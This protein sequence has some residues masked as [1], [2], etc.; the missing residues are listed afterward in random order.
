MQGMSSEKVQGNA[1]QVLLFVM[2][3]V[4]AFTVS[5]QPTDTDIALFEAAKGRLSIDMLE[6]GNL[7][8]VQAL[9]LAS[10]YMQKRNKPNSGYNYMGL[11]RRIAMGIA[12]H[13]EFPTW[14]TN[15]LTIEMRRRVW[16]C[17]YIFD[18]GAIITFSRP[19][20]FPDDGIDVELP[21][22]IHDS[23]ITTGTKQ[24]PQPANETTVYTHLRAQATFHMASSQIYSRIISSPF[25]SANELIELDDRLI[26]RWLSKIPV[27]FQE[28]VIQA[29]K[30]RL[31][32]SILCWRYRNFRILMYRP[33]LVGRLMVRQDRGGSTAQENE[34][35]VE[36]A[37]QRCL[38]SA[39]ESVQLISSFWAQEQKSMMA[40]WYGLYFLFQA[41]LIPVIC[42]RND[43]QCALA[44]SWRD[45][46]SQAMHVLESMSHLNPTASRCL[47]V[48]R[49]LCGSYFDPSVDRW[50]PTE[51]SPQTQ[52]TNLY[53]LMW[54][55]L[56]MAQL[57]GMDP[58]LQESTILDF[59]NQLPGFE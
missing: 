13:K 27:F 42:L 18:V 49:S 40:C 1:W 54:P 20:D 7:L 38:D 44:T 25:P 21:M 6:T 50:G 59:M 14:E 10:N 32:H 22:N 9:S 33:F 28:N 3:A 4:G 43:P 47:G 41:V 24:S 26:G 39:R 15:L 46:I 51:E 23:D 19:L 16:Y 53:P 17:L 37:I 52:L 58:V 36:V 48:I 11:A 31:C 56:E 29:P 2:A 35:Q 12:L 55:T 34:V 30:F 5:A 57:D 8:L 45:Q